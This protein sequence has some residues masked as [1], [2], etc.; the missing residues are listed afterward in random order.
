MFECSCLNLNY[1]VILTSANR[2]SDYKQVEI[3]IKHKALQNKI[4]LFSGENGMSRA[5]SCKLFIRGNKLRTDY[6]RIHRFIA[7]ALLRV[8]TK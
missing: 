8:I 4:Q 1:S 2:E 5:A 6:C 7:T 3:G